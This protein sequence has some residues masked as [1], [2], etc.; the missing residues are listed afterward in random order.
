MPREIAVDLD[1]LQR[2]PGVAG[3]GDLMLGTGVGDLRFQ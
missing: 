2:H 3:G 1:R